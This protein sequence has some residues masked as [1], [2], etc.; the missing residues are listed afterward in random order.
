[1]VPLKNAVLKTTSFKLTYRT[2]LNMIWLCLKNALCV[3]K[4]SFFAEKTK[5][6]AL[7]GVEIP[8][9]RELS[10]ALLIDGKTVFERLGRINVSGVLLSLKPMCLSKD[11]AVTT[12]RVRLTTKN[13]GMLTTTLIGVKA[14][15]LFYKACSTI[16]VL[17]VLI[18]NFSAWKS[19]QIYGTNRKGSALLQACR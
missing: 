3:L 8:I 5:L 12:A 4:N 14:L 15:R 16:K 19:F 11:F 18:V 6:P 2:Y 17:R 13:L 9:V 7:K 10:E 1:M